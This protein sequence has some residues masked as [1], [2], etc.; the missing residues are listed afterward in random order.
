VNRE[1][2]EYVIQN[3]FGRG[4][5]RGR[6]RVKNSRKRQMPPVRKF[7]RISEGGGAFTVSLSDHF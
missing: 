2:E 5:V 7:R 4:K 1:S 3:N 6:G